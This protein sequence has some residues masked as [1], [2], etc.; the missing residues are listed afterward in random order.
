M[1]LL[2]IAGSTMGTEKERETHYVESA[3]LG[4]N[5]EACRV[6]WTFE[7]SNHLKIQLSF[8]ACHLAQLTS[9]TSIVFHTILPL[10]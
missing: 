2:K 5:P 9:F 1:V 4:Y 7:I 8:S 6:A 10:E 3:E